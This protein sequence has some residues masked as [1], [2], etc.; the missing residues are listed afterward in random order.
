MEKDLHRILSGASIS[1]GITLTDRELALFSIYYSEL[2]VWNEKINLVSAKSASDIPI[3]H[4]L[5]SL[6]PLPFMINTSATI[7]DIGAGAG[8]PGIPLKIA[9]PSLKVFLLESSRKKVSFLK[10]IIRTLNLDEI[11]VIH[12][13]AEN[14]MTDDAYRERFDIV[15][16]RAALKLPALLRISAFFLADEGSVMAMKGKNMADEMNDAREISGSLGLAFMSCHEIH[17]PGGHDIRK[18]VTFKKVRR[19]KERAK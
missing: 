6:T 17:L 13:R 11:T 3:K 19:T 14:I 7:L 16:S 9:A 10:H 8:F 5:D 2:I 4:F 12:N 18:I 15:I 1:M